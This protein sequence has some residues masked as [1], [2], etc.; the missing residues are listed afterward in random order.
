MKNYPYSN[1]NCSVTNNNTQDCSLNNASMKNMHRSMNRNQL[2]EHINQVSFAVD[3]VK[4]LSRYASLRQRSACVFS[5]NERPPQR[6]FKNNML[7]PTDHWLSTQPIIPV[8]NDGTGSMNR[9]HGRKEDADLCGIMKKRLQ[10]PVKNHT[11]QILKIAK[12]INQS[13][14]RSRRRTGRIYALS[15]SKIYYAV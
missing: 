5:W 4:T 7:L 6:R 8:P 3:E 15:L 11:N 10:Y 14:R 13:I 12:I 9:G 1:S 2:M